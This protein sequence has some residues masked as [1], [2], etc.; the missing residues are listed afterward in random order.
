MTP[1]DSMEHSQLI[2]EVAD[3]YS[4]WREMYGAPKSQRAT[5]QMVEDILS[6]I[7]DRLS[8]WSKYENSCQETLSNVKTMIDNAVTLATGGETE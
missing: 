4:D 5:L 3:A 6:P 1:V 8:S 7:L 2:Q